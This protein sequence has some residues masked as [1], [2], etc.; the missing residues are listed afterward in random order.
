[1]KKLTAV[2]YTERST[3]RDVTLASLFIWTPYVTY[4]ILRFAGVPVEEAPAVDLL[5]LET[6]ITVRAH[7]FRPWPGT[8][9]VS[10]LEYP[11]GRTYG[12][13][14]LELAKYFNHVPLDPEGLPPGVYTIPYPL[15]EQLFEL[16]LPCDY[17]IKEA[18]GNVDDRP[19]LEQAGLLASLFALD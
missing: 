3:G 16:K 1:M 13:P 14:D 5:E 18:Y 2:A 8:P 15:S 7:K 9:A 19:T 17:E 10:A 11:S 4:R 12:M 6:G